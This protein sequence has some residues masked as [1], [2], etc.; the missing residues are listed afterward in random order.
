MKTTINNNFKT[1]RTAAYCDDINGA[2]GFFATTA[3]VSQQQIKLG[4]HLTSVLTEATQQLYEPRV[5]FSFDESMEKQLSGIT[6]FINK[7]RAANLSGKIGIKCIAVCE[8]LNGSI[9]F[10][11]KHLSD[12]S[13]NIIN[14]KHIERLHEIVTGKD[15]YPVAVF[16]EKSKAYEDLPQLIEFF[17]SPTAMAA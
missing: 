5:A 12:T 8:D 16:D 15:L 17:S 6:K 11:C 7:K 13:E 3:S 4:L 2:P 14:G 9:S 10:V 1:I